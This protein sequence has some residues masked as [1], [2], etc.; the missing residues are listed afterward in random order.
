VAAQVACLVDFEPRMF[1]RRSRDIAR[2]IA[3]GMA[4][5]KSNSGITV[6]R[7]APRATA[8]SIPR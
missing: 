1:A 8:R 2:D 3:L 5:A 7:R 4:R 6:S